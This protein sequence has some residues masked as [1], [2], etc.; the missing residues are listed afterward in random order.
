MSAVVKRVF[1]IVSATGMGTGFQ[2]KDVDAIITNFHVVAGNRE[3]AVI[4]KDHNRYLAKVVIVNPEAD[5]ALLRCENTPEEGSDIELVP[6]V[7]VRNGQKIYIH[8]LPLGLPYTVTEGIVSSVDQLIGTRR[9]IQT[10]AAVN[11]GNSGGPMLDV[12]GKLLGVTT[13]KISQAENVGFGIP[14]TSLLEELNEFKGAGDEFHVRCNSCSSLLVHETEFCPDCGN[15]IDKSVFEQVEITPFAK[16][17]EDAIASLDINPVLARYGRAGWDFHQG[18]AK[19]RI[20]VFE[21]YLVA[22]SCLNKLPKTGLEPLYRYLLSRP[23]P[24]YAL[25]ISDNHIFLSYRFHLSDAFS[26]RASE[27]AER[28]TAMALAADDLD[29][30][31]MEK[32]GCEFSEESREVA[33]PSA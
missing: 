33:D 14:H 22:S 4:S 20:F 30:Q 23:V 18:S 7:E 13:C 3:V 2:V 17:I 25:G 28:L 24:P 12:D 5:I 9:F 19:I 27:I 21:S 26:E 15:T 11:P 29:N 6:D 8:G 31:L 10:D 16:F 32:Y 1:Q